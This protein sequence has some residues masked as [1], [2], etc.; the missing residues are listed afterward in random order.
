MGLGIGVTH[1][2][3]D[4][5]PN[6]VGVVG[7]ASL[8]GLAM[9]A[10]YAWSFRERRPVPILVI[11][12]AWAVGLLVADTLT[13]RM[14]LPWEDT[15]VG[16]STDHAIQG[17]IVGIV[18]GIATAIIGVPERLRQPS[19]PAPTATLEPAGSATR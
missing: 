2:I 19:A 10:A 5:A 3:N 8:S 17:L 1:A 15:P 9:A 18:W 12:A 14:G 7:V 4:G 11:G 13:N 6:A 16:W